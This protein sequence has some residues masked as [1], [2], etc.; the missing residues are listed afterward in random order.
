M[1]TLKKLCKPESILPSVSPQLSLEEAQLLFPKA[2]DP[3]ATL[4]TVLLQMEPGQITAAACI[5]SYCIRFLRPKHM[6][7]F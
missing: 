2:T 7:M 6:I 3:P 5:W 4:W 1:L